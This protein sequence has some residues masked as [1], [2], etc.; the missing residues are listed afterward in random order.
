M[1]YFRGRKVT[2]SNQGF[3]LT[4]PKYTKEFIAVTCRTNANPTGA[5][6]EVNVKYHENY[7]NPIL[8][9]TLYRKLVGSLIYLTS[10]RP[11]ISYVMN[12]VSRYLSDLQHH[13]LTAAFCYILG[14]LGHGMFFPSTS[15][16]RC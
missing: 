8:N 13:H 12:I 1:T 6:L 14:T 4:Q 15:S 5:L 10:T 3:V 11:D 2:H 9:P 16:R 7:G